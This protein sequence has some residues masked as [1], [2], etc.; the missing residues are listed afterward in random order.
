M[1]VG[2]Y[3]TKKKSLIE[4]LPRASGM[5]R[6]WFLIMLV[7]VGENQEPREGFSTEETVSEK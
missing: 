6:R 3:L 5:A 7:Y 4:T 2:G 1:W